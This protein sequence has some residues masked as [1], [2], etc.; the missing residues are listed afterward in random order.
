MKAA[1]LSLPLHDVCIVVCEAD[2]SS[3]LFTQNFRIRCHRLT[4]ETRHMPLGYS[5]RLG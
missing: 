5:Y 3:R 2:P 4:P 1:P